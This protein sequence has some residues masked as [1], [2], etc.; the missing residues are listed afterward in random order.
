MIADFLDQIGLAL[1]EAHRHGII[2]RDL[3]P[4]NIWL[5]PNGRKGYTVN[6]RDF[7]VAKVN[8]SD[9]ALPV[10]EMTPL[11]NSRTVMPA[12]SNVF[13]TSRQNFS[14]KSSF[15]GSLPGASRRLQYTCHAAV[16]TPAA[17]TLLRM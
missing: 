8:L 9:W 12:S 10:Q 1:A 15:I 17:F 11:G 4:D 14:V 7:A 13:L 5:E 3:K 16:V 2:H 6:V